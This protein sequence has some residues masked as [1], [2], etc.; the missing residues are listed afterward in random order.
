[1]KG[2]VSYESYKTAVLNVLENKTERNRKRKVL[3][4]I[5]T[6]FIQGS[7]EDKTSQ[8]QDIFWRFLNWS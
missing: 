5:Y 3:D 8:E 1:M 6:K 4:M 7:I 2:G